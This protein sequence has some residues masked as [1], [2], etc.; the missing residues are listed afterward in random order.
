M[1]SNPV[2]GFRGTG[3]SKCPEGDDSSRPLV[4]ANTRP[5]LPLPGPCGPSAGFPG[6]R[7]GILWRPL[8][9]KPALEGLGAYLGSKDLFSFPAKPAIWGLFVP[10]RQKGMPAAAEPGTAGLEMEISLPVPQPPAGDP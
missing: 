5:L 9:S 10:I 7:L 4:E 6:H 1:T 2:Q 8:P 3:H